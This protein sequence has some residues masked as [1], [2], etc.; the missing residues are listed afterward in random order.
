MFRSKV[1]KFSCWTGE[2]LGGIRQTKS[3]PLG[4]VKVD[5]GRKAIADKVQQSLIQRA[6]LCHR[7]FSADSFFQKEKTLLSWFVWLELKL[8]LKTWN[9]VNRIRVAFVNSE[10]SLTLS[11]W[12]SI[13]EQSRWSNRK[14]CSLSI[15]KKFN[16]NSQF[17]D[18]RFFSD[19]CSLSI[20]KTDWRWSTLFNFYSSELDE[21]DSTWQFVWLESLEC[22]PFKISLPVRFAHKSTVF[23]R[24]S[25]RQQ[26]INERQA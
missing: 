15:I 7:N 13:V 20:S 16:N 22:D 18:S 25:G 23:A 3:T 26:D 1:F 6:R 17:F 12:N 14:T 9:L 21:S 19:F 5:C 10:Q 4:T 2:P 24:Q 11:V 8:N